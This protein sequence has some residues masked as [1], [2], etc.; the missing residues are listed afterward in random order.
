[1]DNKYRM[2]TKIVRNMKLQKNRKI[3]DLNDNT[4]ETLRFIT[5]HPG[6]IS[7]DIV[8][9]LAVDKGLVTRMIKTLLESG[10]VY[11]TAGNDRRT[12]VLFPTQKALKI[13]EQTQEFE[14]DYYEKLFKNIDEK[15]LD[16]FFDVLE[17]IYLTSKSLR[18]KEKNYE[19]QI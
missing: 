12:K 16:C 14:I 3:S 7:N 18:K 6:C 1:M 11:L 4:F 10:Y 17:K 19:D 15:E 2:L 13:K 5:K 8:K 9:Y